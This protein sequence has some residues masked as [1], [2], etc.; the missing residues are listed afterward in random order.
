MP[1]AMN[2][3]GEFKEAPMARGGKRRGAGRK[4]GAA[5]SKLAHFSTRITPTLRSDLER[6]AT[7][8]GRSLSQEVADRLRKS[9]TDDRARKARGGHNQGIMEA[10]GYLALVIEED[11]GVAWRMDP[12]AFAALSIAVNAWFTELSRRYKPAGAPRVPKKIKQLI[13]EY[14]EDFRHCRTPDEFGRD[15]AKRVWTGIRLLVSRAAGDY[16]PEDDT[17][18]ASVLL[19][20]QDLLGIRQRPGK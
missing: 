2:C 19:M 5:G 16:R 7:L 10:V 17:S 8:A 20:V 1:V 13:E 11:C 9:I 15:V 18:G 14:P 3:Y 6:A 4:P 12:F